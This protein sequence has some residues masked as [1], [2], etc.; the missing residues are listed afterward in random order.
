VGS[1]VSVVGWSMPVYWT[2]LILIFIF[3]V[4]LKWFPS[5]YDTTHDI[6]WTSWSSI[7]FQIK[8][9]IM[10]VTVLT[11]FNAAAFSRFTR[12]SVLDNLNQDYVRT[13]RSKGLREFLVVNRHV[14]R[15]SLIPVVTLIALSA[16]GIFAGAILT[17]TV[18]RINGTG[19]LLITAIG[20][21]DTPMI[22]TLTFFFAV[23][24]VFFN[25]VADVLYGLLDPRI[26]YD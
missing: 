13:A 18:F 19:Q 7:W 11:A 4:K 6:Q 26:R 21:A 17:E 15:N 14:V 10:P 16:A 25:I 9:L 8:Q 20:Q 24:T 22:Q 3:S 5:F 12:A 23:M 2:G 1:F